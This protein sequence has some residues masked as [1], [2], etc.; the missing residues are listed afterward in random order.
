MQIGLVDTSFLQNPD[1][2]V[3]G[4]E[5]EWITWDRKS[6]YSQAFTCF[7]N[8]QILCDE[9]FSIPKDRRIALLYESKDTMNW[10]YSACKSAIND[11]TLFFTH[12]KSFL[13]SYPNAR[14]IPGNGIWIGNSY[15]QGNI[16]LSEKDRLI[17]FVT[18]TKLTTPLQR[19]R[20]GL[21]KELEN[22]Q[23]IEIDVYLRSEY[24]FDYLPVSELLSRYYFSLVIENTR[25]PFYFTEKLLNCFAVGTIPIYLGAHEI[26]RFFDEKG[27]IE[28]QSRK[29]LIEEI[30]PTLNEHTYQSRIQ[31]V[32]RNAIECLKYSSIEQVI[33]QELTERG[34]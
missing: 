7:T 20:V 10:L 29:Q 21:A 15:G 13:D 25:S 33:F 2:T 6:P 11:Y 24:N 32:N 1:S 28:F 4:N 27:I 5:S 31:S 14:W 9:R 23:H 3:P 18:S 8:E 12:E 30:L 34:I 22:A 17:S 26:G 19:L 16:G